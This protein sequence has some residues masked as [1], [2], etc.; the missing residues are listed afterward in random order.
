MR[1][2]FLASLFGCLLLACSGPADA[3]LP[4]GFLFGVAT[5]GFQNDPGCPTVP[6]AEC[7]DSKSDWYEYVTSKEI[8]ADRGTFVTGEPLEDAPGSYELFPTDFDLVAGELRGNAVRLSIEWSRLFP[9][10]TVQ[11]EGQEAL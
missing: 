7:T 5:A 2:L 4:A 3:P 11:A 9:R 8:Q 10:S 1:A 6:A